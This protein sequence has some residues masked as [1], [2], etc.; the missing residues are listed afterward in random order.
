MSQC[1]DACKKIDSR[2]NVNVIITALFNEG[3]LQLFIYAKMRRIL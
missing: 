3:L 2:G 1:G